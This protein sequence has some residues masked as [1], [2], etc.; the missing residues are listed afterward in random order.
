MLKG[1][2]KDS[3]TFA[4]TFLL[5]ILIFIGYL[6]GQF[7]IGLVAATQITIGEG[8]K[9]VA[10]VMQI[11]YDSPNLIRLALCLS[12]LFTFLFPAVLAGWMMSDDYREFLHIDFFAKRKTAWWTALSMIAAFPALNFLAQWN[13]GLT[14]PESWQWL[15]EPLRAMEEQNQG[16]LMKV[17]DTGR[18]GVYALNVL[19][20]ALLAGIAEEFCFRGALQTLFSRFLKNRH[21]VIW[22]VA[23]IFSAVH[24]QFWGF[25]PRL[26][27]GAYFG[28]LLL[29]TRSLWIPIVAHFTNNFIAVTATWAFHNNPDAVK[30]FDA[31]G[32]GDT[33][34]LAVASVALFVFCLF[35]IKRQNLLNTK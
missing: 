19:I 30:D 14:L 7:V 27:L 2:Y 4:K 24:F 33:W 18:L 11:F 20:V 5:L 13:A 16:L 29:L 9:S 12:S 31:L 35:R 22:S 25:V 17:L 23:F 21:V 15:E 26:L 3:S 1:I 6:V 8:Q 10:E 32:S 28:Y 34:W